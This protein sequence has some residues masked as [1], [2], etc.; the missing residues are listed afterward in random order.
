M[1]LLLE[2]LAAACLLSG[3]VVVAIAALGVAR[4][5]DPFTRLHAATKT[6]PTAAPVPIVRNCRRVHAM[7]EP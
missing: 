7:A 1:T 2:I 6:E 3:G 5:P 4:F